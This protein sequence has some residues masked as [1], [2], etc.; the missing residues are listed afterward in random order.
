[1]LELLK[2]LCLNQDN[3]LTLP[4]QVPQR[5]CLAEAHLGQ[6]LRLPLRVPIVSGKFRSQRTL[7]IDRG[8]EKLHF[9]IRWIRQ[10]GRSLNLIRGIASS[11]NDCILAFD[12]S[13]ASCMFG[14]SDVFDW[15]FVHQFS[16]G[17]HDWFKSHLRKHTSGKA[18]EKEEKLS[19]SPN[20]PD[21]RRCCP[22]CDFTYARSAAL[23]EHVR[24]LIRHMFPN[25]TF[26]HFEPGIPNQN[27]HNMYP[28][29]TISELYC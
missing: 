26:C 24:D 7:K 4:N 9:K 10:F 13:V 20:I 12:L 22:H 1:M 11:L 25:K 2:M 14:L 19:T 28:I 21:R 18:K 8:K 23:A 3:H 29:V 16:C 5:D 6:A 15:V 17:G 27:S